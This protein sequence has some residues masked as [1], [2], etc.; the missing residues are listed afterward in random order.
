MDSKLQVALLALLLA[1][2][3][4]VDGPNNE[5]WGCFQLEV[6]GRMLCRPSLRDDLRASGGPYV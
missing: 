1:A 2:D 5:S 4:E 6:G 3:E